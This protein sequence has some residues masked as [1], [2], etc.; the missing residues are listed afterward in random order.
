MRIVLVIL[1]FMSWAV[2]ADSFL[3]VKSLTSS[4]KTGDFFLKYSLM[5]D[6]VETN[7]YKYQKNNSYTIV[8]KSVKKVPFPRDV[9]VAGNG[10]FVAVGKWFSSNG[11]GE[12]SV[13]DLNSNL[14]AYHSINDIFTDD[15]L[16]KLP[17]TMSSIHW[18]CQMLG[19]ISN[20]DEVVR[21][22]SYFDR[23]IEIDMRSGLIM[24]ST[25]KKIECPGFL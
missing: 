21:I 25:D 22:V 14:I 3:P 12:I 6:G 17:R 24:T 7:L 15:E 19:N 10:S 18:Y 2:E 11:I 4:N 16:V 23:V 5:P 9:F 1:I 20:D 8:S 13:Y